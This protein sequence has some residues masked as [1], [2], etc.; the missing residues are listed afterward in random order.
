MQGTRHVGY[1]SYLKYTTAKYYIPSGR[2]I[3]SR[4]YSSLKSGGE[5]TIVP[6]S[7]ITEFRTAE[8]VR[9]T[10]AEALSPMSR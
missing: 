5:V 8:A 4:N 3:Q 7:L 2:C 9:Y 10:T 6:D 1:N